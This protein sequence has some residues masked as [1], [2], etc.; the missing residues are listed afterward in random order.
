MQ[1]NNVIYNTYGQGKWKKFQL[2][3]VSDVNYRTEDTPDESRKTRNSH[4]Y[5]FDAN[6]NLV[7][8][9]TGHT[10]EDGTTDEKTH[11]RKLKLL[12]FLR[13]TALNRL[14]L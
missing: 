4:V 3:N 8:V 7:Y 11:E 1:I 10:K 2:Y 13:L 5:E 9:N 6:G 14:T 12:M